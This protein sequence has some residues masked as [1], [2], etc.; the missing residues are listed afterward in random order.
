MFKA[1]YVRCCNMHSTDSHG[2]PA[3]ATNMTSCLRLSSA[4]VARVQ[5]HPC[6]SPGHSALRVGC[7]FPLFT[8]SC[9]LWA[10]SDLL[11]RCVVRRVLLRVTHLHRLPLHAQ[12]S[13][14]MQPITQPK[15]TTSSMFL[16]SSASHFSG[17]PVTCTATLPQPCMPLAHANAFSLSSK[18][19]HTGCIW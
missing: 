5:P 1:G 10:G 17:E 9:W 16:S 7:F 4:L 6:Q 8:A 18:G 12:A 13:T 11:H 14:G 15:A 3:A 19:Y 2:A